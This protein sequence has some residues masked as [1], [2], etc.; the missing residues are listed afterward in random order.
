VRR[1]LIARP[2]ASSRT[3]TLVAAAAALAVVGVAL[4][5]G[6]GA[7]TRSGAAAP[8]LIDDGVRRLRAAVVGDVP[9]DRRTVGSV[10]PTAAL[11]AAT[12]SGGGE[13]VRMRV[14]R[15]VAA[16][17]TPGVPWWADSAHWGAEVVRWTETTRE[18]LVV[19]AGDTVTV[20]APG[21]PDA[22][23]EALRRRGVRWHVDGPATLVAAG[24]ASD[25]RVVARAPGA[26]TV[27][28]LSPAGRTVVPVHVRAAVRGRVLGVADDGAVRPVAARIVVRRGAGADTV[29]TDA[30]GRF[31]APIPEGWAGKADVRV[32]PAG[33]G[34]DP[35]TLAGVATADLHTLGVVLPP[36]RWTIGAGEYAGTAVAVRP[37]AA[38]GFWR[39]AGG[40]PV[41]WAD[42]AV[43]AVAFDAD[44]AAV[45][46]DAFW[47]AAR[48]LAWAWGRPL[49]R[50]AAAGE[51]PDVLVGLS[52]GIGAAGLTTLGYDG[53]GLVSG[54]RIEFRST[55]TAA[56]ARVVAHEL[57]HVLGFGH[58]RGWPSLVGL[59][60]YAGPGAVTAAD[61]AH[62][63]LLEAIRRAA[64]ETEREYGATLGWAGGWP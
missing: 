34:H 8:N 24:P 59:S 31:R 37:A 43:K 16:G 57:V 27:T 22:L 61:V 33:T 62:G 50:P 58:A 42:D 52:P 38:R 40:H 5:A 32:E 48:A 35:V 64:R 21:L 60:G 49:F 9:G 4:R 10:P 30:A 26:A 7:T 39:S 54:A 28:A 41:G 3:S 20:A 45:D 25:A 47:A 23:P 44:A 53:A 11:P 63:Q 51:S 14:P 46:S 19:E 55:A 15:G 1:P 18:P 17:L 13:R 12:R 36:T 56:D 29:H 2:A 6:V